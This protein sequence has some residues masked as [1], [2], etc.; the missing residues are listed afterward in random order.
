MRSMRTEFLERSHYNGPV[1]P[2]IE[3]HE[4][5]A[6][7]SQRQALPGQKQLSLPGRI[8]LT[9]IVVSALFEERS[10]LTELVSL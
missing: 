3:P 4:A 1:V 5:Y 7:C 8:Q 6:E 2:C 9:Y 10:L